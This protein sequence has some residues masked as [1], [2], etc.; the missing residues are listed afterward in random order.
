[1]ERVAWFRRDAQFSRA[2]SGRNARMV[3]FVVSLSFQRKTSLKSLYRFY[4][5]GKRFALGNLSQSEYFIWS[6]TRQLYSLRRFPFNG[7]LIIL[8]YLLTR[9]HISANVAFFSNSGIP[10]HTLKSKVLIFSIYV[11]DI[12][13]IQRTRWPSRTE[14]WCRA[15]SRSLGG[16]VHRAWTRN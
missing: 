5:V 8:P 6:I 10:F 1:M 2:N 4:S 15:R 14:C 11:Q 7:Q 16:G 12:T 13:N 9:L 3:W